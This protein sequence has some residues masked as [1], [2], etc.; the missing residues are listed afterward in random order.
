MSIIYGGL[1]RKQELA[2]SVMGKDNF[3]DSLVVMGIYGIPRHR[4][5]TRIRFRVLLNGI[6][7]DWLG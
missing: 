1:T 7:F 3:D 6:G 2:P 5:A 4:M